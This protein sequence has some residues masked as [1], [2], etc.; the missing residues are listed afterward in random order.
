MAQASTITTHDELY[1]GKAGRPALVDVPRARFLMIDGQGSPDGE[2]FQQ[3]VAALYGIAYRSKFALRKGGGPDI[4]VPPLEGLFDVLRDPTQA[5]D[6]A[7]RGRLRWTLMLRLR[8][9]IEDEPVER[10]REDAAARKKDMEA[11]AKV[12]IEE[13]DE[14]TCAQV[15]HIGPY[16]EEPA[17][18]ELLRGFIGEQGRAARGRHHEIYLSVPGRTKPERMKTILRQPVS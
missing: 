5:F 18:I 12:R 6:P 8:E 17:T 7:V 16:S 9:P 4:K 11:L 14:G 3:A 1:R 15:L 2:E 13:F 10:A